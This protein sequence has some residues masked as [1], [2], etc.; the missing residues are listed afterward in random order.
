M[1]EVIDRLGRL[2]PGGA[3][4]RRLARLLGCE[5]PEEVFSQIR[6]MDLS[7]QGITFAVEI[8][9]R[10]LIG[11]EPMRGGDPDEERAG[12][13]VMLDN[14]RRVRDREGNNRFRLVILVEDGTPL[15]NDP[16]VLPDD[17][18]HLHFLS[19]QTLLELFQ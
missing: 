10:L 18:V 3:W 12:I 11:I 2:E 5:C 6:I 19:P 1:K 15:Q 16:P 8:G 9:N 14:G 17:R 13:A 7:E 4:P